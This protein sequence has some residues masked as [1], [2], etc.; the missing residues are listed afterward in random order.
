[1]SQ[2]FTLKVL[3]TSVFLLISLQSFNQPVKDSKKI[4][5]LRSSWQTINIG[6]IAH[7]PGVLALIE[8]YLPEAEVRLWAGDVGNGVKEML[9]KRFPDLRIFLS[10]DTAELKRAFRECD[11]LLHGSGPY[12]VASKDIEKWIR[13]TGKPF[14]VDGISLPE[15]RIDEDIINILN[16]ARFIYFRDTVSLELARRK[17][18][19]APIME[20]GPDGAFAVDLRNDDAALKF[21]KEKRLKEGRFVC[22]IPRYRITPGW[23]IP[24][25]K[26][27]FDEKIN[28]LNDSMKDSDH[29]PYRDAIIAVV[30]QTRMKVLICPEDVTQV[31]LGKEVLYDPLPEKI[32]KQVVWRDRYWLTDEALSTYIRSAGLFGLEQHSPIMCIGN[33]I[34]ALVGRFE[35][36]T[37][38]GYMWHNIGLKEWFFDSDNRTMML[39]LVP[40]VLSIISDHAAA[41]EKTLNAKKFVEKKQAEMMNVLLKNLQDL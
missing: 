21:M 19:R 16:K 31:A 13:E 2:Q 10:N 8:K 17:G 6:D 35:E 5:L 39:K 18:V 27:R 15:T 23:K 9:L 28:S 34:P 3:F 1:M 36:Q 30:E 33:G 29:K 4:I 24:G 20:F 40:T 32:K 26:V 22:V 12:L 38:K 14:G 37:S 11:F 7:T 41:R 25:R